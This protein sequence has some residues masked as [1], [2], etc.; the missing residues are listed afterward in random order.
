VREP[1]RPTA[2]LILSRAQRIESGSRL[3]AALRV[4][5]EAADGD[6]A[7]ATIESVR[8]PLAVLDVTRALR[9]RRSTTRVILL[10]LHTDAWF[11]NDALDAGVHGDVSKESAVTEI[12]GAIKER[13]CRS[14]IGQPGALA[15]TD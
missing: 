8:P 13:A 9:N 2:C 4:V 15:P 11:L 3:D 7:L 6:E 5:G 12:A 1:R 10:T 14:G